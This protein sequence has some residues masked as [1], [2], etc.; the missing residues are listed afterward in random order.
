MGSG[1]TRAAWALVV[2]CS[3][4]AVADRADAADQLVTTEPGYNVD[5]YQGTFAWGDDEEFP[6][7]RLVLFSGGQ[8][9]FAPVGPFTISVEPSLGPGRRGEPVAAYSRCAGPGNLLFLDGCDLFVLDLRSGRE[10]KVRSLSSR[11]WSENAVAV[12]GGRYLF[13]RWGPGGG[14]FLSRPRRKLFRTQVTE[15]DLRG[16][17]AAL[18]VYNPRGARTTS[19]WVAHIPRRGRA[20][21]CLVAR[22]GSED[23][24]PVLTGRFVYWTRLSERG[25]RIQRRR[26][27]SRRCTQR[28]PVQTLRSG[29]SSIP[30]DVDDV[31]VDGGRVYYT[32]D[33]ST[34]NTL[35]PRSLFQMTDPRVQDP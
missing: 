13:A 9:S 16:A 29:D 15:V 6:V 30:P 3:A 17:V 14:V 25:N 5:G 34:S 24:S 19:I 26:I 11:R 8:R 1:R 33:S 21:R 27:P 4:G 12:W 31:A 10:R 2:V 32:A 23:S 18:N 35:G 28:G 22:G 20:R 7:V